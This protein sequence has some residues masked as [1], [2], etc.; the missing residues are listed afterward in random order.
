VRIVLEVLTDEYDSGPHRINANARRA[1]HEC[2]FSCEA[3]ALPFVVQRGSR[4]SAGGVGII[5]DV[6]QAFSEAVALSDPNPAWGD[7]F[8]AE[9]ARIRHAVGLPGPAV[10]H[11]G[12]T[13]VPLRGKPIIDIQVAVEAHQRNGVI[14]HL[15]R[16]GYRH[17]GEGGIPG[18]AY[19][20]RRPIA[21]PAVNV[22]VFVRGHSLLD[23]NRM[24]RDYLRAHPGAAHDYE[25]AKDRA[26]AQG[27]VD[28][29]SYSDAKDECVARIREAAHRWAVMQD[30]R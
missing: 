24:I 13:S 6:D 7:Q 12:S 17:H 18:R 15:E 23:D 28:L 1:A 26:L 9:A 14:E 21:G 3:V 16:L 29:V 11:I 27:H 19:L 25:L 30:H 5:R 22:H 8:A 20:T 2:C 4:P 10:E